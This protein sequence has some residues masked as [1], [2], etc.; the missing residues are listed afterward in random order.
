MSVCL[1]VSPPSIGAVQ[2]GRIDVKLDFRAFMKICQE[3]PKMIKM[4]Q[5][6]AL[7]MKIKLCFIVAGNIKSA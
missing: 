1:S 4:E 7:Y 6:R 2:T 3:N 5:K